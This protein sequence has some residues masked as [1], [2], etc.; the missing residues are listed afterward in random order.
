MS[1][2]AQLLHGWEGQAVAF[3]VGF[4]ACAIVASVWGRKK[5]MQS[6][7]ELVKG[8]VGSFKPVL[9]DR[10]GAAL[11]LVEELLD[12]VDK[13]TD[14]SDQALQ[15]TITGLATIKCMTLSDAETAAVIGI[16]KSAL[17]VPKG[18][19]VKST[20][21]PGALVRGLRIQACGGPIYNKELPSLPKGCGFGIRDGR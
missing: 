14:I 8:L 3:V 1:N 9:G 17:K 6:A 16:F 20:Q 12:S 18:F 11:V 7:Q 19:L 10:M 2:V 13:G 4:V 15:Q 21:E 5:A